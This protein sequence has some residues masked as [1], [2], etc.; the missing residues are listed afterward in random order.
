MKNINKRIDPDF[1]INED[2]FHCSLFDVTDFLCNS[3]KIFLENEG[4]YLGIVKSYVSSLD[5]AYEKFYETLCDDDSEI[6]GK[7]LY[8]IK[9]LLIK[10]FCRLKSKK[11]SEGDSVILIMRKLVSIIEESESFSH[12][13]ELKTVSKI[14]NRFFNNIKNKSKKDAMFNFTNQIKTLRNKGCVGKYVLDKLDLT[15]IKREKGILTD[16]NSLLVSEENSISEIEWS[17]EL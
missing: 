5:S 12:N 16:E 7:I 4:R 14:I 13:K 1:T 2:L 8:L 11:L 9:P 6:Y 15:Q 10:E 17:V 3:L